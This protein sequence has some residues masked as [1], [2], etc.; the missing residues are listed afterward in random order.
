M[1]IYVYIHIYTYVRS[2]YICICMYIYRLQI[3]SSAESNKRC[4]KYDNL[5]RRK[6]N[7]SFSKGSLSDLKHC[8]IVLV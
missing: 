7:A 2:S 4:V 8:E 6:R 5:H 3:I 1:Y